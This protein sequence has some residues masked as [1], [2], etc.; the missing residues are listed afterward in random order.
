MSLRS[1]GRYDSDL[2]SREGERYGR[3]GNAALLL[4]HERSAQDGNLLRGNGRASAL[5]MAAEGHGFEDVVL[6]YDHLMEH[7]RWNNLGHVLAGG[8]MDVGD[9]QGKSEL[10]EAYRLGKSIQ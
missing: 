8:N 2:S 1:E 9:I 5:L 10:E 6:Y 7:L 4:E 3:A